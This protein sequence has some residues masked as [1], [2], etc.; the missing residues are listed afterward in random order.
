MGPQNLPLAFGSAITTATTLAAALVAAAEATSTLGVDEDI[1]LRHD[2][3]VL[4]GA[5]VAEIRGLGVEL[6]EQK[7][8][9]DRLHLLRDSTKYK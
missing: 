6:V 7:L 5:G 1:A 4:K 8:R 9:P 2:D 3:V